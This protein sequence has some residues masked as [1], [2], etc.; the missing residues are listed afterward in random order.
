MSS[1]PIPPDV[2]LAAFRELLTD[3]SEFVQ[4]LQ[5]NDGDPPPEV[6]ARLQHT[7][8]VVVRASQCAA[9]SNGAYRRS[10]H[11]AAE[12]L[13]LRNVHVFADESATLDCERYHGQMQSSS[14]QLSL[15]RRGPVWVVHARTPAPISAIP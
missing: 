5:A 10:D 8:N 4:C 9:P 3:K 11:R 12:F 6:M 14:V 2:Q 13:R 7:D 1:E 15:R